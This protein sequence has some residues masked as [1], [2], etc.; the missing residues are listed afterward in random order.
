MKF[1]SSSGVENFEIKLSKDVPNNIYLNWHRNAQ[2]QCLFSIQKL[3]PFFICMTRFSNTCEPSEA[4]F[5]IE[6]YENRLYLNF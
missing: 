5:E 1:F 2:C 3:I 6:A 4:I